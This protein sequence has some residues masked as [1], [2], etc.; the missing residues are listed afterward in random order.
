M[1]SCFSLGWW[2]TQR[3]DVFYGLTVVW[4]LVAVGVEQ[5][6]EGVLAKVSWAAA[7]LLLIAVLRCWSGGRFK[8]FYAFKG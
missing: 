8:A 3:K 6:N 4:A 1:G 5:A 7:G 2:L